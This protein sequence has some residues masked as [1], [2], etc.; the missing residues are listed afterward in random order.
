MK[1]SQ[2]ALGRINFIVMGIAFF[3]IILGFILMNGS[4]STMQEFDPSIFST[5][6]IVIAPNLCFAGY[7]LMIVGI[8][9]KDKSKYKKEEVNELD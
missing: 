5:R 6:R 8:L 1:K 2:F 4:G 7:I 3:M 9:L